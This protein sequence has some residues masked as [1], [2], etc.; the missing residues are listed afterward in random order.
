MPALSVDPA[1]HLKCDSHKR[2]TRDR[3]EYQ[4]EWRARNLDKV[5][6]YRIAA[7]KGTPRPK[8]SETDK[9][10]RA[11]RDLLR[12]QLRRYSLSVEEYCAMLERQRECC[13]ICGN[14]RSVSRRLFIDHCHVTKRVRGLLCSHCNTGIGCFRDE[15]G[16]L[17]AAINYLNQTNSN[18]VPMPTDHFD[19]SNTQGMALLFREELAS[20]RKARGLTQRAAAAFIGIPRRTWE[21]YESGRRKPDPFKANAILSALRKKKLVKNTQPAYCLDCDAAV[22]QPAAENREETHD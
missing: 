8:L 18:N 11:R 1:A 14:Q 22:V 6:G 4:R 2:D 9:A 13:A 20:E 3:K 7:R 5:N 12:R 21:D 17:T 15:P 10:A 16:K 19:Q